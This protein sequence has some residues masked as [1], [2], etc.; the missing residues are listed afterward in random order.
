M[1]ALLMIVVLVIGHGGSYA[2]AICHHQDA[3]EHAWARQS[4][5]GAVAAR[6]FSEETAASVASKE[7]AGFSVSPAAWA[8]DML[9]N[10]GLVA[11]DR[12]LEPIRTPIVDQTRLASR[13]VLPQLEPPAA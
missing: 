10:Q 2:A 11:P 4:Q 1:L 7:G 3:Q 6:A 13:S 12:T 9:P 8:A 5:D